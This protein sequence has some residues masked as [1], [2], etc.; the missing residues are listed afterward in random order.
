MWV[1]SCQGSQKR[2]TG[3]AVSQTSDI[4]GHVGYS[5]AGIIPW[6]T[7]TE[8]LLWCTGREYIPSRK[9]SGNLMSCSFVVIKKVPRIC[10]WKRCPLQGPA[11]ALGTTLPLPLVPPCAVCAAHPTLGS[12]VFLC[13]VW[14]GVT[15][16]YLDL[17]SKPQQPSVHFGHSFLHC[18]R[19]FPHTQC[20]HS[21]WSPHATGFSDFRKLDIKKKIALSQLS[22][23][24]F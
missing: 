2:R 23:H 3:K 1:C 18:P 8:L 16:Y 15:S 9:S 4:A 10:G 6:H 19:S 24:F 11:C 17:G 5:V 13:V 20:S 22:L 12:G 14:G 7:S 21:E